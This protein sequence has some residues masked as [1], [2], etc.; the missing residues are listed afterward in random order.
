M[1]LYTTTLPCSDFHKCRA[2][3]L[4]YIPSLAFKFPTGDL[5]LAI[6]R[7]I[8]FCPLLLAIRNNMK[9]IIR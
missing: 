9:G 7:R 5:L 3:S 8:A 1:K 6:H 2:F 4:K